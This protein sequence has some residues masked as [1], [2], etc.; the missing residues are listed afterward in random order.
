MVRKTVK[1]DG[2]HWGGRRSLKGPFEINAN[3]FLDQASA[4]LG[5]DG[6]VCVP[7]ARGREHPLGPEYRYEELIER[8]EGN[9]WVVGEERDKRA[10]YD[11]ARKIYLVKAQEVNT[12]LHGQKVVLLAYNLPFGKNL[13]EPKDVSTESCLE[14][15]AAMGCIIGLNI[16]SGWVGASSLMDNKQV[17][18]A[19]DFVVEYQGTS[20]KGV[21]DGAYEIA[22][23]GTY[24][25]YFNGAPK[26]MKTHKIGR[27]A[28]SGGHRTPTTSFG[29]LFSG[30]TVGKCY[31]RLDSEIEPDEDFFGNLR[32]G[33]RSCPVEPGTNERKRIIAETFLRHAPKRALDKTLGYG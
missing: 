22:N 32:E 17:L 27:L 16:P 9:I 20:S 11:P 23:R 19:L 14:E 31:S 15:A 18:N 6:I 28:V 12:Q 13:S 2:K 5:V 24:E 8:L 10:V 25:V 30:V 26:D 1:I 7:N 3:Q 21:N 29:K 4:N 33:I